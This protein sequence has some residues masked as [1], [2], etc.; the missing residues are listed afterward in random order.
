[1]NTSVSEDVKAFIIKNIDLLPREI[2]KRLVERGLN[3]NIRQKQIHFWWVELESPKA[4]GFLTESQ[5]LICQIG[6]DATYNTN[7]LKF[8]LYVIQAEID[9]GMGFPLVSIEKIR[10]LEPNF[11]ITDKD[12]AQ[13]SAAC[14]I[15]KN[16]K[17]QLCLWHIKKAVSTR[18]SSSKNLQVNYNGLLVQQ[19]FSFIDPSFKPALT[20]DKRCFCPK[21]LR[22]LVWSFMN[23]HLHQHPMIPITDG[24]FLSSN[25]IW[26]M[27]V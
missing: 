13:I 21:E 25:V 19:K 1:M 9:G 5:F 20:K 27:A 8:E 3:T 4:F 24:Q 26:T 22:S 14:F 23:K 15:W 17:I 2:Y 11:L 7:N 16:V 6:I 12:F 10:G 18:L